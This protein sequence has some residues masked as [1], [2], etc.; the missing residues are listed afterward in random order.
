MSRREESFLR[1]LRHPPKESPSYG[2]FKII[3]TFKT[4]NKIKAG[5][6]AT[7]DLAPGCAETQEESI[8][9]GPES[10]VANGVALSRERKTTP[11]P[12]GRQL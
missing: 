10:V 7:K 8:P 12:R 4:I 11:T 3:K 5:H 9:T 6:P 2:H 1:K